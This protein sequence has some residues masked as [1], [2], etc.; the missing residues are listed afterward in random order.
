MEYQVKHEN[1][2]S[3]VEAGEG[4]ALVLLHGLMGALSNFKDVMDHF[5]SRYTVTIPLMPLFDIPVNEA[6]VKPL[7]EYI[8]RF[9]KYKGYKKVSLLG[10]SLGGHVA[11]VYAVHHSG[12]LNHLILTGSSGLYENAFGGSYPKREDREFIRKK[13]EVTFYDPAIAGDEL[14]DEVFEMLNDRRK[15]VSIIAI[16]KNAIRY[17]MADE[18]HHINAPTCLIWGRNDTI[19]PPEV[20]EDFK[21][22]IRGSELFW[23]DKC[24]HA[25]MMEHPAEFNR[26]LEDWLN[27]H[28]VA[29]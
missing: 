9:V 18:L 15:L 14:V 19:T 16:A 11:L 26:V 27:R 29:E 8:R 6:G 21:R 7:Y 4:P 20:G 22:L 3:Y 1:E 12:E 28:P 23:I 24:G 10:N 17:N 25:P 5:K 2:F 13:V